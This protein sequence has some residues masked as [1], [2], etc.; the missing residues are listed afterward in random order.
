[1]TTFCSVQ[2]GRRKKVKFTLR[3]ADRW[4]ETERRTHS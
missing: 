1:M 2:T 3:I 4:A